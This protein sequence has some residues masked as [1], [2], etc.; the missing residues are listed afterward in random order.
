MQEKL[1]VGA[2]SELVST[3][4][5]WALVVVVVARPHQHENELVLILS[6]IRKLLL[7]KSH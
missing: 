1:H 2:Y 3:W 7:G 6:S 4:I 5:L